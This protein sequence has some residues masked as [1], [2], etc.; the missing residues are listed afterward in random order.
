MSPTELR[1]TLAAAGLS[2]RGAA[3]ELKLNE[4]TV[5]SYV[6]GRKP[7]PLTVELAL[8]WIVEHRAA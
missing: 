8:K 1:R 5:R 6:S 2:Q 3:R 7:I 4:R